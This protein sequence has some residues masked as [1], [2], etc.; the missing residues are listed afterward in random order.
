MRRK[1]RSG[2]ALEGTAAN[3]RMLCPEEIVVSGLAAMND[4]DQPT[5]EECRDVAAALREMAEQARLPQIHADLV[6][7]ALRFERMAALFE[8]S[9]RSGARR[10]N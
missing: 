10:V 5:P 9:K 4:A 1:K 6:D 3:M 2:L 7:L 8:A